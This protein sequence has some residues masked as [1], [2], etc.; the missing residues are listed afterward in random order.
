[1]SMLTRKLITGERI[2]YVDA[3][4]PVN[5]VFAVSI[6]GI[7]EW[8]NLQQA[9]A[10]IQARHPLLRVTLEEDADGVPYFIYHDTLLPIPVRVIER[11]GDDDWQRVYREEWAKPFGEEGRQENNLAGEGSSNRLSSRKSNPERPGS[12]EH[13]KDTVN[14][15]TAGWGS[16]E[17]YC[18]KKAPLIRLVWIRGTE[19]AELVIVCPHCICDGVSFVALMRELLL[20]LDQPEQTL[21]P[22]RSFK[23]IREYIPYRLLKSKWLR[24]KGAWMSRLAG[25]LLPDKPPA[26]LQGENYLL[27]WRMDM[28]MTATLTGA[29]KRAKT[30]VHGALCVAFLQAWRER[31]GRQARNR[32][33]CPVD[34]RRLV[35]EIED[36]HM[37]AFAPIVE[38][39]VDKKAK[40][41][42]A[43]ACL[44]KKQLTEKVQR[45]NGQKALMMAEYFHGVVHR[46][47]RMLR[48]KPGSHDFTFSNMGQLAIPDTYSNF[49]VNALYSPTVAFPWKNP[50]TIVVSSFKKQMDCVI[51][52]R[53]S[54]LNREDALWIKGRVM[55]ILE[56]AIQRMR[57]EDEGQKQQRAQKWMQLFT[58]KNLLWYFIT[59]LLFNWA[60]S[61]YGFENL[62]AVSLFR[63]NYPYARFFLPMMV[64][65]P[66]F[67]TWDMAQRTIVFLERRNRF[68]VTTAAWE[69]RQWLLK[70]S[71]RNA[72]FCFLPSAA[73]FCLLH[74]LLPEG[75]TFNGRWL[76]LLQGLLAAL[77][78]TC[79]ALY[80]IRYIE[81][82]AAY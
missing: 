77:L 13:E 24:W 55:R 43:Q 75:Y 50:N 2:M 6:N 82:R 33:I 4:T 45:L 52:S 35:P 62:K 57:E 64:F 29:C 26:P 56:D 25:L 37:F 61:Y 71:V 34:I 49:E 21:T 54:Y 70:L 22:Y 28:A 80:S 23:E 41:F 11:R 31:K 59:N 65:L 1:M 14:D 63:G 73:A 38:V 8:G 16:D 36:G 78:A 53:D 20:L 48:N 51:I 72:L 40:G 5:C 66:F 10:K 18:Q 12:N 46:L 42:W 60:V 44:L 17:E 9:L 15:E 39:R 32:A 27:H 69:R 30:S 47:V 19:N 68:L 79:C 58:V 7:I 67:I 81:R 76:A 74:M 3:A